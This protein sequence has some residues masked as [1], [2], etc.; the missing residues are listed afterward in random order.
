VA[1]ALLSRLGDRAR[2]AGYPGDASGS[3]ERYAVAVL[4][5]PAPHAALAAQLVAAGT[6]VV[7]VSDD[8]SDVQSLFDL[9][10]TARR[11]AIP[12]VVGAG[13]SPGLSG[14]LA[15]HLTGLLDRA[16]EIYVSVHGTG[17]PACARQHHRA[18]AG[19]AL[20]WHDRSWMDRPAGSGRELCWF[21]DPLGAK[22]CYRADL[23]DPVL[24]V[25]AF[26]EILRVTAR[27]SATRRDRLTA[28]LPMMSPP[29]PEGGLGGLRVE[30]RGNRGGERIVL[31]AGVAERTAIVTAHVASQFALAAARGEFDPGLVLAGQEQL[32]TAGLLRAVALAGV[33]L[34]EFVGTEARTSW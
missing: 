29:H 9:A 1:R 20:G 22:D 32:D 30:V 17:G 34:R 16:D 3:A 33:E 23:A 18:L 19:T 24:L 8:R 25:A 11:R 4:A 31:V 14:L 5:Q 6:A 2:L 21:P 28:R 15:R 10:E 12:V 7:S 13:L 27:L 26:P